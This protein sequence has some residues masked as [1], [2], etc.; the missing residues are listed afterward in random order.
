MRIKD[1]EDTTYAENKKKKWI[2]NEHP[3]EKR[4]W[5]L[6]WNMNECSHGA[7]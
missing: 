1:W 3:D 5:Y 2:E 6:E 7:S 4:A